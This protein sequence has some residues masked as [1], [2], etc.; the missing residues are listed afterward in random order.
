M[1]TSRRI[2]NPYRL[3]SRTGSPDP[4]AT[5][6]SRHRPPVGLLEGTPTKSDQMCRY[7]SGWLIKRLMKLQWSALPANTTAQK[8]SCDLSLE[9]RWHWAVY[10]DAAGS[11][12]P[13]PKTRS[14]PPKAS[15]SPTGHQCQMLA[16]CLKRSQIPM[17]KFRQYWL[18][19]Y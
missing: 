1:T 18:T 15:Q 14:T 5:I 9:V 6:Y 8:Y 4:S 2:Q 16:G 11:R 10:A 13:K 3:Q 19:A 17:S 7:Q 12:E